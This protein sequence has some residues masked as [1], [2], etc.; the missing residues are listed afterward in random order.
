MIRA[1]HRATRGFTLV[2]LL[3]V[4]TIIGILA[5]LMFVAVGAAKKRAYIAKA[6]LETSELLKAWNSYWTT[7]GEWPTALKDAKN[8]EMNTTNM[9][10]LRGNNPMDLYLID[11]K[12]TS[13]GFEDPWRALYTVDFTQQKT[14]GEDV[15]EACVALPLQRGS[16]YDDM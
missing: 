5:G 10:Y 4:I 13:K 3:T 15:Y 1:R 6:Q 7:F 11:V 12:M 2:E 14:P 8:A 16:R 9:G